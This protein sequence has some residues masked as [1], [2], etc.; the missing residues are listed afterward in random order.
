MWLY[1]LIVA[2]LCLC[3]SRLYNKR[4]K[5]RLSSDT[6]KILFQL[7]KVP[8]LGVFV[9]EALISQL[10]KYNYKSFVTEL[11]PVSY[12]K[13]NRMPALLVLIKPQT[14]DKQALKKYLKCLNINTSKQDQ[15]V[16]YS[17][18]DCQSVRAQ[19][20]TFCIEFKKLENA[21]E[22]KNYVLW[23]KKRL[24]GAV[25]WKSKTKVYGL[26]TSPLK[27][28]DASINEKEIILK[29][30]ILPKWEYTPKK[31]I[32]FQ[33]QNTSLLPSQNP[34]NSKETTPLHESV[35]TY[36]IKAP[37]K[38]RLEKESNEHEIENKDMK[39]GDQLSQEKLQWTI[40]SHTSRDFAYLSGDMNPIHLYP[41]TAKLFG[42]KSNV[43]HGMWSVG[44]VVDHL[45]TSRFANNIAKLSDKCT[46]VT[47][48]E[49]MKTDEK[50]WVEVHSVFVRPL[51]LP[52]IAHVDITR[53]ENVD[54]F[55]IQCE[56][57]KS[58]ELKVCIEGSIAYRH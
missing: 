27:R 3:V 49:L 39:L 16:P 1:G 36:L 25:H 29:S 57:K 15:L 5:F 23:W 43:M 46:F 33:C 4:F 26:L 17:F 9:P 58:R 19:I 22:I 12:Y 42:M 32:T 13:D 50:A 10:C 54:Q 41:C 55:V 20:Y 14:I 37:S 7:D 48:Q 56:D 35:N 8:S 28:K 52:A 44:K 53:Y 51:F 6:T 11:K 24:L 34:T 31:D 45:L 38:W 47:F 40:K 30:E 18:F 2:I 21:F